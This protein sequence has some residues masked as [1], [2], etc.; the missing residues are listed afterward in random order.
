MLSANF[1]PTGANPGNNWTQGDF[2]GNG[3]I[4]I[5]DFTLL[6]ASLS[7]DGYVVTVTAATGDAALA[8]IP[9]PSAYHLATIALLV[10]LT[11]VLTSRDSRQ[12][13]RT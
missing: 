8:A 11:W 5:T 3:L 2:D 13:M 4:D 9:E 10:T 1:D 7:P 12:P 6:S